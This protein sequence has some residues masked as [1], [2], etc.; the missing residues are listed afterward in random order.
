MA[1]V[2]TPKFLGTIKMLNGKFVNRVA[3]AVTGLTAGSA[4]TIPH[5]LP[6][7]PQ[8]VNPVPG[9]LGL[10]GQTSP[11]DATNI[12][13]TVGGGGATAGTINVEYGRP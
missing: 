2:V 13:L 7:P 3:L 11:A 12:Y 1:I 8:T 10:W 4:N 6:T 9:A 5:G